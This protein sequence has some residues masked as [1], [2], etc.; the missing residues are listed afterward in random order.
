VTWLPH[1]V[2]GIN[3]FE[4]NEI[5]FNIVP[6]AFLYPTSFVRISFIFKML[7]QTLYRIVS[8]SDVTKLPAVLSVCAQHVDIG[9]T[10]L[11]EIVIT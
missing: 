9:H 10:G 11:G 6:R 1:K 5:N 3:F 7:L 8:L 4:N 2:T